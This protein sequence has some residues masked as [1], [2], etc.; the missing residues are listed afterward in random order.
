MEEPSSKIEDRIHQIIKHEK[1]S[2]HK[3]SEIIGTSSSYFNKLIR[4][5]GSIGSDKIE[6][7]LAKYPYVDANWL[8]TGAGEMIKNNRCTT[9]TQNQIPIYNSIKEFLN[10]ANDEHSQAT[11][12]MNI[13]PRSKKTEA[14]IQAYGCSMSPE[15][16]DGS[17]IG[18]KQINDISYL[19][20][21]YKYLIITDADS[22]IK[23]VRLDHSRDDLIFCHSPNHDEFFI[24]KTTIRHIYMITCV[25][26]PE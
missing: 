16:K 3:F 5:G 21:Q 24:P 7:I 18:I 25:L 4:L 13:I 6:K 14:Y 23:Y 26:N 15:I 19:D 2:T 22:M 20:S 17:I 10:M 1:V 9:I 12:F 8:M 11:E